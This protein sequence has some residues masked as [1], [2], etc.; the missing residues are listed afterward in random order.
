MR[1]FVLAVL[2]AA[3]A[4]AC[5]GLDLQGSLP[6][7]QDI[8]ASALYIYQFHPGLLYYDFV[9]TS[10]TGG[11]HLR[12]LMANDT[13][14]FTG[15][16]CFGLTPRSATDTIGSLV[17]VARGPNTGYLSRSYVPT[18]GGDTVTDTTFAYFL[19]GLEGSRGTY[20][21]HGSG[22]LD[23]VWANGTQLRYFDSTA[24][25]SVR[26]DT[27]FSDATLKERGDSIT[28]TWRVGWL[29]GPC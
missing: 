9:D 14:P 15:Y 26:G 21:L 5:A 18:I 8:P 28:V 16:T 7:Q 12:W 17:F 6:H 27:I 24:A 11:V 1:R 3:T 29:S 22:A 10:S 25:I 20:V 23:L 19:T 4:A 2:S 13:V